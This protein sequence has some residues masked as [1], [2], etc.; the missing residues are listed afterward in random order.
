MAT[1]S[2]FNLFLVDSVDALADETI[3][4]GAPVKKIKVSEEKFL[5]QA[6]ASTS[7]E[8]IP[9]ITYE[10]PNRFGYPSELTFVNGGTAASTL[11]IFVEEFGDDEADEYYDIIS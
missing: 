5:L 1:T 6:D 11:S 10:F 4:F 3:D 2:N 9:G 8:L 7:V